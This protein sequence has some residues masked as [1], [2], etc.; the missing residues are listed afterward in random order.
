MLAIS[1]HYKFAGGAVA[2]LR[3]HLVWAPRRRRPVLVGPVAERLSEQLLVSARDMGIDVLRMNI[4]P[5]R[6][7]LYISAAPDLA[8]TQIV[9]RLKNASA[10][11]RDEFPDL[12]RMPSMW[13]TTCLVSSVPNLSSETIEHFVSAQ[14]KRA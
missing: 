13:T 7:H 9:S 5:D 2:N 12:K 10:S 8:P 3:Y 11:L 6:V 1:K 4:Q 14:S